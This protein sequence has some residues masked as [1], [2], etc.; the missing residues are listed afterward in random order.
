MA[1]FYS[2]AKYHKKQPLDLLPQCGKCGLWEECESP[3]IPVDGKGK[4]RVL[5]VGEGPGKQEDQQGRPFVGPAGQELER[6]LAKVGVDMRRDCWITNAVI[7]RAH[8]VVR[9]HEEN[10]KPTS[11]QIEFCRPNLSKSLSLLKPDVIIPMGGAAVDSVVSLAWKKVANESIGRW[12]GWRIPSQ[13]LNAWICPTYHPS[14]LLRSKQPALE[15]HMVKH[16]KAAFARNCKPWQG[17]PDLKRNV[18]VQMDHRIAKDLIGLFM[19]ADGPVAFDYETTTL[20]PDG[21]HAQIICCSVSDGTTSIAFPWHGKAVKAMGALLRSKV[22]KI[23]ANLKFEHRW[24]RKMLGFN[25]N[26]WD[27][28]TML[29]AH[30]INCYSSG[31]YTE[32]VC[33]LKFQAFV[34]LGMEDYSSHLEPYMKGKGGNQP[35]RLKEVDPEILL[36]YC[37]MDSLL[38]HMVAQRQRAYS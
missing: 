27:F 25:I 2:E 11:Q 30:W 6:L 14:Y 21:K 12:A 13:V 20:K 3:K 4:R 1:G 16:L 8:G 17:R 33:G 29:G 38:E 9:G 10:F 15:L 32:G 28:D 19:R 24:T 23:A 34:L 18:V 35:N 37:G 7:C 26:S 22:P 5:I 31:G 36:G